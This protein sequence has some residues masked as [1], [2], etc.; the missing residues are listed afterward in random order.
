MRERIRIFFIGFDYL[1]S[2]AYFFL[3]PDRLSY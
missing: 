3:V 2:G 1:F